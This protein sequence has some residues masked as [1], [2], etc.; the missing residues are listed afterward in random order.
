[1]NVKLGWGPQHQELAEPCNKIFVNILVIVYSIVLQEYKV[2][3]VLCVEA[4]LWYRHSLASGAIL[5]V[6]E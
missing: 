5:K 6:L 1:M 3:L 2:L 4:N